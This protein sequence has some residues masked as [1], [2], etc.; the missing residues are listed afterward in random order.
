MPRDMRA[1]TGSIQMV[2]RRPL[3]GLAALA[4]VAARAQAPTPGWAPN[5]PLHLIV[6]IAPGGALDITARMLGERLQPLLGQSVVVEN[7]AGAGGNIGAEFVA[8]A[9]KDGHTLLIGA[10]NTLVANKYL[11]GSR[12]PLD[13]LKDLAPISR[14]ST[15]TILMVVNAKRPWTSFAELVAAA[16]AAPGKITMGSSG[17]G[18]TSHLTMELVKKVAGIDITH[19]P[20]RGGGPAI[21]D[22]LSGN[23]D[24]M[25]D[26]MPALMPHVRE[27]RFRA[28][29]VG[30]ARRVTYVPGLEAVPGMD[31][32]LPGKGVDAQ[33]WYAI[34][35][36]AGTPQ[37]AL[38]RLHATI[39]QVAR[40]PEFGE[41]LVPLG[42]Q[43]VTDASPEEF[44]RFL[45]AEEGRWRTLVE[46]S[47]AQAE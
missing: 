2:S 25:F 22:L 42:F 5:R 39:T 35:A 34:M 7:R 17:T 31:E 38:A 26:V 37:P 45:A 1:S 47:G 18:T 33:V 6:P 10:A 43:P 13:P 44:G 40:A 16:R 3:L 8:R 15:G 30:S 4:P 9:E 32:L 46:I 23:I 14:V 20:Y 41:R 12:M 36:P 19:V 29:A 24:M 21:Q 11:Y 27:G 28:L